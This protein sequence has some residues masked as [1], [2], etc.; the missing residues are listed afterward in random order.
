MSPIQLGNHLLLLPIL[1][2]WL[3]S[4]GGA[5]L[6]LGCRKEGGG[7]VLPHGCREEEGGGGCR[8]G[9]GALPLPGGQ[10]DD[11]TWS[12]W[13]RGRRGG[14]GGAVLPLGC[15]EEGGG[16]VLP[17]VCREEGGDEQRHE[18]AGCLE[19]VW[20]YPS[21]PSPLVSDASSRASPPGPFGRGRCR[22]RGSGRCCHCWSRGCW[23]W[24][25][26]GCRGGDLG[27]RA[28]L[29][30]AGLPASSPGGLVGLS[31][32]HHLQGD[33]EVTVTVT[34]TGDDHVGCLAA[35]AQPEISPQQ[36]VDGPH[37]DHPGRRGA[38]LEY[39]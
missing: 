5:V 1:A 14:G 23:N 4:G 19:K 38:C 33:R 32:H 17:L 26:R 18:G 27:A 28:P 30:S 29:L 2:G 39:C 8:E 7:A 36:A 31:S 6:P 3:G 37:S 20:L 13:G 10:D 15:R 21:Q 22:A 24:R 9:E 12:G 34:V 16:A 25:C 11:G 35:A